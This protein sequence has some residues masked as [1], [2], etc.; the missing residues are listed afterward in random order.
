M[1]RENNEDVKAFD[2]D[3]SSVF[4][5][6]AKAIPVRRGRL[7]R[8]GRRLAVWAGFILMAFILAILAGCAMA[9]FALRSARF[10]LTSPSDVTIA[11][12]RFVS[13]AEILAAIGVPPDTRGLSS[14]NVFGLS[15]S[16]EARRVE[17]IPWIKSATLA[18]S[19]PHR[20]AI[21]V[22]A[23]VPVAFVNLGGKVKLVD[24]DGVILDIPEN[25]TFDFPVLEGLSAEETA[26][27]R[28]RRVSLYC[29]FMRETAKEVPASGWMVSEVRLTDPDD[30]QALLVRGSATLLLHL[31]RRNF[32]RRFAN[33]LTLLPRLEKHSDKIASVDLR[34]GNQVVVR[35]AT[36]QEHSAAGQT[37]FAA[38]NSRIH[39]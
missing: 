7:P 20:L 38:E 23:R 6:R 24:R 33:F 2:D 29:K 15:L 5:R 3:Q 22:T 28:A 11:G 31:G 39:D 30:L 18:R 1:T 27:E 36:P 9:R 21:Y 37:P 35:P 25:A 16:S 19:F 13:P 17:A 8:R 26:D 34:Y 12:N 10:Q 4:F 32:F 14:L